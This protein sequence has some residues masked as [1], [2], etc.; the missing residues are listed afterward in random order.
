MITVTDLGTI[1]WSRENGGIRADVRT[2]SDD[3]LLLY[4]RRDPLE[5][6]SLGISLSQARSIEGLLHKAIAFIES[7]TE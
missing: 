4:F 3:T 1:T 5:T 7:K 6:P 2:G